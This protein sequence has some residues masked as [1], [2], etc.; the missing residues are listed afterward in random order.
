MVYAATH[1][2]LEEVRYG[3]DNEFLKR[4]SES[5]EKLSKFLQI[6]GKETGFT[7]DNLIQS[8]T[9]HFTKDIDDKEF[10]DKVYLNITNDKNLKLDEM[11][12]HLYNEIKLF[13]DENHKN[14]LYTKSKTFEDKIVNNLINKMMENNKKEIKEFIKNGK[15]SSYPDKKINEILKKVIDGFE[16]KMIN[17]KKNNKGMKIPT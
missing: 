5:F 1:E 10:S 11:I 2:T 16:E 13:A 14:N 12:D 15:E 3:N 6:V 17:D 8:N 9:K 7:I 4:A